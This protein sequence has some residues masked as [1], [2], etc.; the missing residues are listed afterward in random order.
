MGNTTRREPVSSK[1][2]SSPD[3]KFLNITNFKGI[4]KSDNPFLVDST[5]ASDALNVYVDENNALTTRPRVERVSSPLV[6]LGEVL[7]VYPLHEKQIY[8]VKKDGVVKY[9]VHVNGSFIEIN[10]DLEE[11]L[12][13]EKSAV[14]EQDGIIYIMTK[15]NY[16]RAGFINNKYYYLS[17]V[18]NH[19]NTYIP[20]VQTNNISSDGLGI[21]S[22]REEYNLLTNKYKIAYSWNMMCDPKDALMGSV[23]VKNGYIEKIDYIPSLGYNTIYLSDYNYLTY[24][25][26]NGFKW[27]FS[28]EGQLIEES[29]VL[30]KPSAF[31]PTAER[32]ISLDY[33]EIEGG[34]LRKNIVRIYKYGDKEPEAIVTVGVPDEE[35]VEQA[36]VTDNGKRF[37]VLL[38][39]TMSETKIKQ[40]LVLYTKDEDGVYVGKELHSLEVLWES[41][42]YRRF[43]V[44]GNESS[45]LIYPL[46]ISDACVLVSDL[47]EDFPI[48]EDIIIPTCKRTAFPIIAPSLTS[49]A[50]IKDDILYVSSSDGTTTFVEKEYSLPRAYHAAFVNNDSNLLVTT[51]VK[52]YPQYK[53]LIG[54]DIAN[55]TSY[56]IHKEP[57]GTGSHSAGVPYP[58]GSVHDESQILY[59]NS[60]TKALYEVTYSKQTN[61]FEYG[62]TGVTRFQDNWWFYGNKNLLY[63]TENNDP[64]YITENTKKIVGI[65]ED[66]IIDVFA[67]NTSSL[68][69]MKRDKWFMCSLYTDDAGSAYIFPEAKS[70]IGAISSAGITTP[71]NDVP[72][73][74]NENGFYILTQL[75]NV[76]SSDQVSQMISEGIETKFRK[77]TNKDKIFASTN[78]YWT[79]FFLP[80]DTMTKVYVLDDR[81]G[82]WYYWELPVVLTRSWYVNEITYMTDTQGNIYKFSTNDIVEGSNTYYYDD[83]KKIIEW[84]W[85][86]QI[87]PMGTINYSKKLNTT[88]FIMTDTDETDSYSLDYK[89][90]IFRKLANESNATTVTNNL[91]Y[92]QSVTKKTIVPRFNFIQLELCNTPEDLDNNK[93]R[94]IAISFK[95]E[96]LAGLM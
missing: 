9:Y 57:F 12:S 84:K 63:W 39:S 53:E 38:N 45:I 76:Q 32:Y 93:L 42:P 79:Y 48:K 69:I 73:Y 36:Y 90:K 7:F 24:S 55:E 67:A 31:S 78:L 27:S 82:S 13:E 37:I 86:S 58:D 25:S 46:E 71:Y 83:G 1:I 56:S 62:F 22:D 64:T 74:V 52:G 30:K 6:D 88:T 43:A 81:T 50:F 19:N 11:P 14:L 47:T 65:T 91:N 3:Y 95:Y 96:L 75:E 29:V 66:P 89:F 68:A 61:D 35:D 8:H 92:I 18:K 60:S 54:V 17:E 20:T 34:Y 2:P 23:D 85:V 94:L 49:V 72:V 41:E 15:N 10:H 80:S 44:A 70:V 5:T 21:P 59:L 26:D 4:H 40:R 16:Y 51:D 87:L 28:S 33:S 77:E